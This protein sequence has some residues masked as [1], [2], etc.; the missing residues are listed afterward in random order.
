[1]LSMSCGNYWKTH[2]TVNMQASWCQATPATN[3]DDLARSS[4]VVLGL[5]PPALYTLRTLRGVAASLASSCKG[6]HVQTLFTVLLATSEI[7]KKQQPA[8]PAAGARSSNKTSPL[9]CEGDV[10][11]PK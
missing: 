10:E 7:Y 8:T 9:S 4:A 5:A 6:C 11:E 1:M 2:L 3:P